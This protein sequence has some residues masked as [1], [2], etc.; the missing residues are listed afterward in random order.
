MAYSSGMRNK[1][2]AILNRKAGADGDFGRNSGGRQYE[3]ATTVWASVKFNK[4]M[5][6]M[7]EG[8][9]DAYDTIIIRMLYNATICRE[10][11]LI[12]DNRTWQIQSFNRDYET[13]EIQVTVVE[14]A[15][16]DLTS[17]LP[18]NTITT[19]TT[20]TTPTQESSDESDETENSTNN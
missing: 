5:K 18:S 1:R 11:V 12:Y 6:S 17:L 4:G 20:P 10:S 14:Y 8:A 7:M 13:N 3:Y 16:K 19:P 2:V 15:G 9:Y